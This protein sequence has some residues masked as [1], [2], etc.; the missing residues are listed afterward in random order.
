MIWGLTAVKHSYGVSKNPAK[1]SPKGPVWL[2]GWTLAIPSVGIALIATLLAVP[3]AT[4]PKTVPQPVQHRWA[5]DHSLR[6]LNLRAKRVGTEPLSFPVRE[7]GEA[8]RRLGRTQYEGPASLDVPQSEGWQRMIRG[9]RARSGDEALLT[10]RAVQAELFV[11]A[12]HDWEATGTVSE[13]LVELGGDFVRIA[14]NNRWWVAGHLDMSADERLV[15][16]LVRWTTLAGF[17][18]LV[19]YKLDRDLELVELRFFFDHPTPG[20]TPFQTR[21]K[22]V[23]RYSELEASYPL[24]YA[25]GVLFAQAGQ[26]DRAFASFTRQLQEH[27]EGNYALRARNHLIWTNEQSRNQAGDDAP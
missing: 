25:R 12:L 17:N 18:Q 3:R 16:A 23:K 27:P 22:I 6:Q 20:G 24:E 2:E 5:L 15:L 14:K 13:D 19:P 21:L 1:G 9:T 8:Y 11:N 10:L 4:E 7:A 26:Y